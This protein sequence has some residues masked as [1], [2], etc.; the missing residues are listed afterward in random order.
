MEEIKAGDIM[1]NNWFIGYNGNPFKWGIE[2]FALLKLENNAPTV[3]ELI[4]EPIPL[5]ED[6]LLKCGFEKDSD[7]DD[8]GYWEWYEKE[9]PVIGCIC[10]S[11]DK[12]YLFDTASDTLR[13][14]YLHQLQNLVKILTGEELFIEL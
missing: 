14:Y 12:S 8:D 4:R 2:R 11:S 9:F 1:L 3:D 13:I 6:V 5:T 7:Y 10:Q